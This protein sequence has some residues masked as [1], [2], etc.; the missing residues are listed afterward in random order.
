MCPPAPTDKPV[1]IDTVV[2]MRAEGPKGQDVICNPDKV[3]A[4]EPHQSDLPPIPGYVP[5]EATVDP[6]VKQ[7]PQHRTLVLLAGET[8][9]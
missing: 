9:V 3:K 5:L 8:H 2:D 6:I 4:F 7:V 1:G